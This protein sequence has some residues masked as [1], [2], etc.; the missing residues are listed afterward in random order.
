M[1][2]QLIEGLGKGLRM[3]EAFTDDWPTAS[4]TG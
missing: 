3:I 2:R 4:T 1:P